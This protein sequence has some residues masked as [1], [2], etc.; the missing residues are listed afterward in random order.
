MIAFRKEFSSLTSNHAPAYDKSFFTDMNLAFQHILSRYIAAVGKSGNRHDK[1]LRPSSQ[2]NGIGSHLLD[3]LCR[4]FRIHPDFYAS[5]FTADNKAADSAR[6]VALIG[7]ECRNVEIT[8]QR[9]VLF[10]Q[11]NVMTAKSANLSGI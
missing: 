6:Q 3:K 2:D 9:A 1:R 7:R 5:V 11:G 10:Q 8:A 4:R